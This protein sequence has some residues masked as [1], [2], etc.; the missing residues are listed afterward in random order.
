MERF[1]VTDA[2]R[3]SVTYTSETMVRNGI[4]LRRLRPRVPI[5]SQ[6]DNAVPKTFTCLAF[7]TTFATFMVHGDVAG[8]GGP[9]RSG[10]VRSG[11]WKQKLA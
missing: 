9:R 10:R 6:S 7:A 11:M 2:P 4:A 3:R 1:S 5:V 8:I